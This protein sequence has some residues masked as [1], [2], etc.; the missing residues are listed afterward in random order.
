MV[1]VSCYLSVC[2][3]GSCALY[4]LLYVVDSKKDYR[5][6]G[7]RRSER[8]SDRGLEKYTKHEDDDE[9]RVSGNFVLL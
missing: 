2:I 3:L 4:C 1:C 7:E 9:D 6:R 8:D 5:G